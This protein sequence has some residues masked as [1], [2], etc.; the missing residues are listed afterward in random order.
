MQITT[1]PVG[2]ERMPEPLHDVRTPE[3]LAAVREFLGRP[4]FAYACNNPFGDLALAHVRQIG[5][6]LNRSFWLIW[7]DV[8]GVLHATRFGR[9]GRVIQEES[10]SGVGWEA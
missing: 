1:I 10:G 7:C 8:S 2:A 4:E 5:R 3:Q 6:K 9:G